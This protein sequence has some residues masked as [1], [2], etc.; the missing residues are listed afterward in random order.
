MQ[1]ADLGN[2]AGQR[3]LELEDPRRSSST[4]EET[5]LVG[6]AAA[7]G[8]HEIDDRQQVAVGPLQDAD[9]FSQVKA[10]Q[11]PAFTVKSWAMTATGRPSIAPT[12]VTTPSADSPLA[13]MLASRPSSTKLPGSSRMASRS[14]TG[15]FVGHREPSPP[16]VATAVASSRSIKSYSRVMSGPS[17]SPQRTRCTADTEKVER[18]VLKV[19]RNGGNGAR[20]RPANLLPGRDP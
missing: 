3:H 18:S 15:S 12:P 16:A 20:R 9:L 17:G 10:P 14:R 7:R 5:H 19:T 4:R 2:S 13:R 1:A 8:V 6:E 11:E